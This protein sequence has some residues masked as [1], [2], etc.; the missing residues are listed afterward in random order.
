MT[1]VHSDA[2]R[3]AVSAGVWHATFRPDCHFSKDPVDR[4][5]RRLRGRG[6]FLWTN[7]R[8]EDAFGL[9]KPVLTHPLH[10]FLRRVRRRTPGPLGAQNR[11]GRCGGL[12]KAVRLHVGPRLVATDLDKV[13]ERARL[14][15]GLRRG[16]STEIENSPK[17]SSACTN[18]V[19]SWRLRRGAGRPGRLSQRQISLFVMGVIR[20]FPFGLDG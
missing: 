18:R 1:R 6:A 11:R 13:G 8:Q 10:P 14:G 5:V 4:R 3:V 9:A 20:G 15:F 17:R 7:S 19:R 12:L 16:A 2:S